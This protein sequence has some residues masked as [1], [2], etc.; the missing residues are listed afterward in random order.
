MLYAFS[1]DEAD[2]GNLFI[3]IV[4]MECW[5]CCMMMVCL[6]RMNSSVRLQFFSAEFAKN[7]TTKII[8]IQYIYTYTANA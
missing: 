5:R 8:N 4:K 2:D 6:F 3:Y 1:G 7:E